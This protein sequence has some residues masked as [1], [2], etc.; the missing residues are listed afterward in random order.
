MNVYTLL[1]TDE[2]GTDHEK[3]FEAAT[4]VLAIE[5]ARDMTKGKQDCM[6]YL[7]LTGNDGDVLLDSDNWNSTTSYV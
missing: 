1:F 6:Q 7:T 2:C 4:D 5:Q 3:E